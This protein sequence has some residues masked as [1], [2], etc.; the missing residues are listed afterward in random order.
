MIIFNN[1]CVLK[2]AGMGVETDEDVGASIPPI[3]PEI[4]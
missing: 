3:I 1:V 2:Q 4:N